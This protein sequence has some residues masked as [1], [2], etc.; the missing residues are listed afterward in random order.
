MLADFINGGYYE[1]RL[2]R[3]ARLYHAKRVALVDALSSSFGS[4]IRIFGK[5]AGLHAFVQFKRLPEHGAL[6]LIERARQYG[7]GVYSATRYFATPPKYA[8]F[9]IGFGATP[10]DHIAE[11]VR[12]LAL[13]YQETMR[14]IGSPA[15]SE[16]A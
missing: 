7:V 5:A 2:R 6:P 1:R 9:L 4:D 13:A 3:A 10:T 8:A 12:R 15:R 11:G 16:G 14:E